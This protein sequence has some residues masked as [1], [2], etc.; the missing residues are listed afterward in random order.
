MKLSPN[1]TVVGVLLLRRMLLV[2]LAFPTVQFMRLI[3]ITL[4]K[5]VPQAIVC[6]VMRTAAYIAF[7]NLQSN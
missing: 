3:R 7:I 4:I 2:A 5:F 6:V 1:L